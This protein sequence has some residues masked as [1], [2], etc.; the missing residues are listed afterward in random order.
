M[1]NT[2][3]L[4]SYFKGVKGII[5]DYGGTLDTGGDHW[6]WVIREAWEEAGVKTDLP[7]FREAYVFGERELA[8]ALHILPHHDFH[9][10]LKIKIRIELQWLSE[11]G[12]FPAAQ[13]EP[14]ADRI[15]SICNSKAEASIKAATPVLEELSKKYP[16]VLVSNFYG[17][18]STVLEKYGIRRYF[19]KIV[20]SAVVGIRKPDPEIFT[21]GVKALEL[22]ASECL[23]V[24]DSY[25]KDILP[26]EKAG[27]KA[28]WIK[29]KGWTEQE[30]LQEY[31]AVIKNLG[32][33]T[34]ILG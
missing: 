10:L 15:A 24:G 20:E 25:K 6:S 23:V 12:E 27:C 21:L 32:E 5:F 33:L 22:D 34:E 1:D 7:V 14:M 30:D 17:N 26:A 29:G 19:K 18:I 3:R 28:V 2:D 4:K 31:K 13:I 16:L 9:D 11:Q 8:R